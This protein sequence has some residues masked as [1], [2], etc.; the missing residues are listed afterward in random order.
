MDASLLEAVLPCCIQGL[1][2][3]TPIKKE[4][5]PYMPDY[6][7]CLEDSPRNISSG[8]LCF[9]CFHECPQAGKAAMKNCFACLQK[10]NKVQTAGTENLKGYFCDSCHCGTGQVD[11]ANP[12]ACEECVKSTTD[13][14]RDCIRA[15]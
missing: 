12:A 8:Y 4:L 5:V 13:D 2:G 6:F 14:E 15:A 1:L 9:V 10:M 7:K 3:Q 11:A